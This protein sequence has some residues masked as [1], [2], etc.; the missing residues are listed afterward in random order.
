MLSGSHEEPRMPRKN[1]PDIE[2][3]P[4]TPENIARTIFQAPPKKEWRFEKKLEE[5]DES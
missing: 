2:P 4:D 5:D 3:I 1:Y